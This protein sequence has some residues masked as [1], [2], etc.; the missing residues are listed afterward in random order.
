M[1]E[2]LFDQFIKE[3]KHHDFNLKLPSEAP[4]RVAAP[5]DVLFHIPLLSVTLLALARSKDIK[6]TTANAG[7]LSGRLIEETIPAYKHSGQ[8]LSWS[9]NLR[10]KVAESI[11]FLE[12]LRLV[13]IAEHIELTKKG[14][15]FLNE[16][17]NS[18]DHL[19]LTANSFTRNCKRLEEEEKGML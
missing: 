3:S 16:V 4:S 11:V 2:S 19:A 17:I 6:L 15:S 1:K 12:R 10:S 13:T 9:A 8:H 18:D 5:N 7:R 14:N